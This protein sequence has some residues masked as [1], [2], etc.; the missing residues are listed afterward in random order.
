MNDY[1]KN[2]ESQIVDASDFNTDE[3]LALLYNS[4]KTMPGLIQGHST[5]TLEEARMELEA[6]PSLKFQYLLGKILR[7]DLNN[8]KELDLTWY[9]KDNGS[10]A[11]YRILKRCNMMKKRT[12]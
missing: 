12:Q 9:S 3:L 5:L 8:I 10:T 4:A 2:Y 11:M 6:N 7:V 1:A